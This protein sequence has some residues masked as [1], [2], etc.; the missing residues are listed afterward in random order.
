MGFY[1]VVKVKLL[2]CPQQINVE[3]RH[4]KA[5]KMQGSERCL[6][7]LEFRSA[8]PGHRCL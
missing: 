4:I 2:I 6:E 1:E 8:K 5:G 3:R 7:A